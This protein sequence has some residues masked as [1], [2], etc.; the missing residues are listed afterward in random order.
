MKLHLA[1]GLLF[2]LR[3][4]GHQ[5]QLAG[6]GETALEM[7]AAGSIDAIILDVM[8]PGRDGFSRR[9]FQVRAQQNFVPILMLTARSRPEDV[10]H[11]FSAGADDY[12]SQAFRSFP[13]CWLG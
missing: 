6:D 8:L 2:N 4:E 11:G 9:S 5:V 12:P 1:R 3:A 13:S 10:L 7:A